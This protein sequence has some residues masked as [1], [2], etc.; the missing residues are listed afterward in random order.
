MRRRVQSK[1]MPITDSGTGKASRALHN[2][3]AFVV[4]PPREGGAA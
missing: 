1:N 3:P 4:T 2:G